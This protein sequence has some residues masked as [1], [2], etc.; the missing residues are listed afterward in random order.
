MANRGQLWTRKKPETLASA[1]VSGFLRTAL[2][3]LLVLLT[4]IELV[5]Y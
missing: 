1:G 2:E 3:Q 5:T 4:G